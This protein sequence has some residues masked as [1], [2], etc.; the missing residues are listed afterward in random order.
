MRHQ[1]KEMER[2]A[3]ELADLRQRA[4]EMD[5]M[6]RGRSERL[7]ELIGTGCTIEMARYSV[8][9]RKPQRTIKILHA[10]AVPEHFKRILPDRNAILRFIKT[11][12]SEVPGVSTSLTRPAV[13]VKSREVKVRQGGNHAEAPVSSRVE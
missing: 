11:T 9:V 8:S 1:Q 10:R 5:E 3:G 2:L 6:I 12:E 4:R 7:A 13:W